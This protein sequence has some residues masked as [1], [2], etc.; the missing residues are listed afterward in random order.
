MDAITNAVIAN[1]NTAKQQGTGVDCSVTVNM[2]CH[3]LFWCHIDSSDIYLDLLT[4]VL[5]GCGSGFDVC[6]HH[7]DPIPVGDAIELVL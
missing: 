6:S 4:C 2:L 5:T 7:H 3:S 1:D